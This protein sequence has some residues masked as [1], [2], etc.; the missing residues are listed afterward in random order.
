M[1]LDSPTSGCGDAGEELEQSGLSSAV[2]TDDADCLTLGNFERH[3]I[4]GIE[5]GVFRQASRP[6]PLNC[7]LSSCRWT[8]TE[9]TEPVGLPQA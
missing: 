3:I 1:E 4:Q 7:R 5:E 9:R 8:F 6:K 2:A